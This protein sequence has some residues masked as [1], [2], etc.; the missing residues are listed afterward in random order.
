MG[1]HIF[2]RNIVLPCLLIC[3]FFSVL[4]ISPLLAQDE[5]HYRNVMNRAKAL[6]NSGEYEE[7][8][9]K[10]QIALF[11]IDSDNSALAECYVYLSLCH[12]FLKDHDLA[13]ENL[14]TAQ[15]Y[16]DEEGFL[17][18]G[19][20]EN[21]L[22]NLESLWY[23]FNPKTSIF[24]G[25]TEPAVDP[26]S[27][28]FSD[29]D[30]DYTIS[31]LNR[32]IDLNPRYIASYYELYEAYSYK[33]DQKNAKKTLEKL[34]K[35]KP[36]ETKAYCYLGK[37]EYQERKYKD[38]V[39]HLEQFFVLLGDTPIETRLI[40][41]AA[42]FQILSLNA[43][44]DNEEALQQASRFNAYLSDENI[45]ALPLPPQDKSVLKE[46]MIKVRRCP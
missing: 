30:I 2:M 20:D 15:G 21:I 31:S 7:V 1:I 9:D 16:L 19:L 13:R 33:G 3:L 44:G 6:F 18:L 5:A 37:L 46:I 24:P 32:K 14:L 45:E 25:K 43:K 10:L 39:E 11:G 42:A 23:L 35:N 22:F 26:N 17:G 36:R 38:A 12:F 8:I 4:S 40:Q 29:E 34:L 27:K 41:E 28:D